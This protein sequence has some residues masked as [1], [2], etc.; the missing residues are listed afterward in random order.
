MDK[1][2][3]YITRL[4]PLNY[5]SWSGTT[6]FIYKALK[7]NFNVT[8]VGPLSNRVRY[9]FIFKKYFYALFKIK[10]DIDRPRLVAKDF[11]KQIQ[12]SLKINHYDAIITSEPYLVTF[13]ETKVPI[14]IYTDFVFSTYYSNY[15]FD[16]KIHNSTIKEGN[17][18]EKIALKKSKK[19]ILTSKYAINE[20]SRYYKINKKKFSKIPFGANL[21]RIPDILTFKKKLFT[22]NFAVCNLISV[23]VHWDRKGMAKACKLVDKINLKGLK[24]KLYIIGAKPPMSNKIS[25]NVILIDFLKK[26]SFKDQKLF[27]DL[28]YK[29]HFHILFS[30]SEAFGIANVEASVF[31][32][33]NITHDIGGIEGAVTNNLNGFRFPKK[34]SID[35]IADHIINIFSNKKNYLKSSIKIRDFY[36]KNLSWDIISL[37]LK[38]IIN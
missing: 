17:Y 35:F 19:I 27:N 1:K 14:Y 23:G 13:L 7:N 15:F 2:V 3:L 33:Y 16:K 20:A 31:G 38:K 29:S 22:K 26:D 37:K 36:E 8:T 21:I 10:F 12:L 4:D 24:A 9:L 25:P 34:N 32:L 11:A 5:Q 6:Y 30:E 28:M 18:C